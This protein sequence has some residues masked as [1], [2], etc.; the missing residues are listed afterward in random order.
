MATDARISTALPAHPKTKKLVRQL[1]PEAGWSLVVLILWA[2]ANRSD[3][4]LA[5][6]SDEDIELA[7][8]WDGEPGA[9]IAALRKIRFVDGAE[10]EC[11]V[12]DWNEHQPWAAGSEARSLKARWNAVKRHHGEHAADREVPEY[13]AIRHA[14]SKPAAQQP[15]ASSTDAASDQHADS[16]QDACSS[17]SPIRLP[18]VSSPT[19]SCET[20]A[21]PDE[22]DDGPSLP[23]MAG[24][25]CITLRAKGVQSVNPSHPDLLS[26]LDSGADIGAFAAAAEK[27]VK[28]G[29]GNFAYVLAIVRG[30]AADSQRIAANARASPQPQGRLDR[31]L[32]TA[33]LL[34]GARRPQPK[35]LEAIDVESRI[36]PP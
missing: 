29:K 17:P 36:L 25:V 11:Q 20:P 26:L 23:T 32:E 8:D 10:C 33:A 5:G 30:Q 6:M 28:A 21:P 15:H 12:H 7:A 35:P 18:S 24:A 22:V 2:A 34:T 1:G 16:M 13:A 4:D 27:A 9:F 31:Q 19:P 14:H 3:G